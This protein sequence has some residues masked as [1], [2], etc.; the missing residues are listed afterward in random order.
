ILLAK[1]APAGVI[2]NE[3]LQV[4]H[5]RGRTGPYLEMPSGAAS[6]NLLK[7]L[8]EGLLVDVRAAVKR[9]RTTGAPVR[10]DGVQMRRNGDLVRVNISVMPLGASTAPRAAPG[11]FL[12]LFEDHPSPAVSPSPRPG[13]GRGKLPGE[14]RT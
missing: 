14:K 12:V 9:A 7:M 3:D 11:A 5:V 1:Y 13:A 10:K 6:F 2:V 8:R 4:L